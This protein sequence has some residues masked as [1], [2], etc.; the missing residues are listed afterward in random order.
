MK[1]KKP[2]SELRSAI[3]ELR[4]YFLRSS[5]FNLVSSLLLLMPTWYML[6][7]Y[8]RVVNSR[9]QTTLVMVTLLV[10][11]AYVA[12][13]IL[14]WVRSD[15]M[16]AGG[17]ALDHKLG[18]RLFN[19]IFDANLRHMHAATSQAMGDLR[20]IRDFLS[21]PALFA[22]MEAPVAL[23]FLVLIFAV[24]PVLGWAASIS[25]L[26]QVFIGWMN[27]RGTQPALTQANQHGFGAQQ[28][29]STALSNAQVIESMG[30]LHN[31]YR[32]WIVKQRE[33]LRFQAIASVQSGFYQSLSKLMQ[34]F[35]GS[36]LL[37]LSAW[38]LLHNMLNG[39]S[40]MLIAAGVLGG[41]VLTPLVQLVA[42]WRGIV[43]A[44]I[45][46]VRVDSLLSAVPP[47]P[48]TMPLPPPKGALNVED[49]F[50]V[51]PNSH[52]AILKGLT[53][54]ILPG[55][56]LAVVGPSAAGKST[57]ARLLVGL[58]E[59]S[60]GKVR[61][62]GVDIFNWNKAELGPHLG[63]LPQTVELFDGSIA[64]N[65][66][67]FGRIDLE[68]VR[69]AAKAV[70]LEPIIMALPLGYDSPVGADG[71][72]LSGGMRQ[73]VG[74]ARA[75]YG[76]PAFVVLDEPNSSL[77]EAGDA[78]LANAIAD[79]KMRGTTFVVMTH[80]TSIFDVSDKLLVLQNGR[81]QAFGPVGQVLASL[82]PAGAQPLVAQ[83]P[84]SI[85]S[86]SAT[87]ATAA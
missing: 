35:I 47:K 79:L 31:I 71:A 20:T 42:Q 10:V 76:E 32:L 11:G 81:L 80:R 54:N 13:E 39:G 49:V 68:K 55:E 5:W 86:T 3:A 30:M 84:V 4:P 60:S 73:R 19:A 37:G 43:N 24:S 50:V 36:M 16:H 8:E 67:R 66:A 38:L 82:Q 85:T 40:A 21:S 2:P 27:E 44:R 61:L 77:D 23:V 53:F 83:A 34:T 59:A 74:L 29:A 63:Y 15:Q 70:G 45:A 78:A 9:S 6:A 26:V 1:I 72:M 48:F 56:V 64:D 58:W 62:D 7:V 57:L 25:A 28:Y 17:V 41:R 12:M 46:W 22:A 65:I 51:A 75:L 14:E 69:A 18:E 52:V 33:F 87:S